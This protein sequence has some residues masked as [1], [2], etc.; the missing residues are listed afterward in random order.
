MNRG[1]NGE[2]ENAQYSYH[3]SPRQHNVPLFARMVDINIGLRTNDM[4]TRQS[5]DL[6]CFKITMMQRK[7]E[8]DG[9]LGLYLVQYWENKTMQR[10]SDVSK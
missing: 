9:N 6:E 4:A 5:A 3:D 1:V 2:N 7:L 8:L 10:F